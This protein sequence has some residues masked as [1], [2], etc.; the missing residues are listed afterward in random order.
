VLALVGVLVVLS[1]GDIVA[2]ARGGFG[3][4]DVLMIGAI[5]AWTGYTVIGR[6]GPRLPP[7]SFTAGQSR[8]RGRRHRLQLPTD[9]C[10]S[11]TPQ[12][13]SNRR[14]ALHRGVSLSAVLRVVK[15]RPGRPPSRQRG[16]V[17]QPH[18]GFH[19]DLHHRDRTRHRH[20]ASRRRMHHPHR[21]RHH[22]RSSRLDPTIRTCTFETG[23][24]VSATTVHRNTPALPPRHR[25]LPERGRY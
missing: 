23:E 24:H 10:P 13:A 6:L 22:L 14:T 17:S 8:R 1:R 25:H 15:P 11:P 4:G 2:L 16:R 9:G 7:I 12:W 18:H 20:R 5:L 3:L 21:R 19:R